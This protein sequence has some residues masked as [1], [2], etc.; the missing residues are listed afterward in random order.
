D[1]IILKRA[2]KNLRILRNTDLAVSQVSVMEQAGR[3]IQ[4]VIGVFDESLGKESNATSGVAIQQRQ[5]AG[6]MSQMFAYDALRLVKKQLGEQVLGLVRQFFTH[7]MVIRV[8]DRLGAGRTIALN[9]PVLDA[10]GRV[11][12]GSDGS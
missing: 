12:K 3:D 6:S 5:V 1:G 4:E 11:V 7:E 10:K 9:R 2:G 8:T